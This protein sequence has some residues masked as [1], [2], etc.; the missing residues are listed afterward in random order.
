MYIVLKKNNRITNIL[1]FKENTSKLEI[2]KNISY[3]I[4]SSLTL[5]RISLKYIIERNKILIR[6]LNKNN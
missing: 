1:L 3:R 4:V 6:S 2:K 5:S